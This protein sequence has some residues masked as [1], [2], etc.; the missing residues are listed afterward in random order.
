M[1]FEILI[2]KKQFRVF[3][4]FVSFCKTFHSEKDMIYQLVYESKQYVPVP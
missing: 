3:Q 2:I 4:F 1:R